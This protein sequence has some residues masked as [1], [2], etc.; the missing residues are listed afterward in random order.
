MW[1]R[2]LRNL[3]PD[4]GLWKSVDWST[5]RK[6]YDIDDLIKRF[7]QREH[8]YRLRCVEAWSMVIPGSALRWLICSKRSILSRML[9]LSSF[10]QWYAPKRC[11]D[12]AAL[13]FTGLY[14]E[15]L[16]IDEAMHPLS[17]FVT[18][19]Y[20]KLVNPANGAPIRM[21]SPW[22]YGFKN[23]KSIVKTNW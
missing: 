7:E 13:A 1:I 23:I 5:T 10:R 15:G 18:G 3:P 11:Q 21:M 12:R 19:M 6:T 8:I 2:F 17:I 9:S 20:G 16:R 4:R 14:V 22:K